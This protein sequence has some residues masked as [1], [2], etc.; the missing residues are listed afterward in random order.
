VGIVRLLLERGAEVGGRNG[1]GFKRFLRATRNEH[2]AAGGLL[3]KS[4]PKIKI[5]DTYDRMPLDRAVSKGHEVV[6]RLLVEKG[7][8]IEAR[9]SLD[10]T[11]LICTA[12]RGH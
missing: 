10:R 1:T 8:D 6:V 2:T 9:N 5:K 12:E 11:P 7:A 3:I 4:W